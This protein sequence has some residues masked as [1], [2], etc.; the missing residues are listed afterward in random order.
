MMNKKGKRHTMLL[1]LN[2]PGEKDPE[3]CIKSC[4]KD[5]NGHHFGSAR[6]ILWVSRSQHFSLRRCLF[7][8]KYEYVN[9]TITKRDKV[10]EL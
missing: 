8:I 10:I 1:N 4:E 2:T 9:V 5:E 6:Y 7:L 3:T